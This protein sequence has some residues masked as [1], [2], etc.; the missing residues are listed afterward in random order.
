[1][2][3]ASTTQAIRLCSLPVML[4]MAVSGCAVDRHAGGAASAVCE[5]NCQLGIS[6]PEPDRPPEVDRPQ[7][8]LAYEIRG[9]AELN[10]RGPFDTGEGHTVLIFEVPAFVD[11]RGRPLH[12]LHLKS[13]DNRFRARPYSD[14]V[15]LGTRD[16]PR[17]KYAVVN[18]GLPTRPVLDPW[19]I[20]R[21]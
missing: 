9:G 19:I 12:V 1:M 21:Y 2:A 10:F 15:C 5:V 16:S 4:L 14:G 7:D 3:F 20:I 6:L 8:T 17:C 13:G 11:E 18:I